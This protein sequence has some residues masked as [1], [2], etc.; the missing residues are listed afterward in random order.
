MKD[1]SPSLV[2]YIAASVLVLIGKAFGF[3]LLMLI[4]KPMVVPAIYFYYLQTKA[5]KT[6][7]LFSI[8]LWSF[9][10]ADMIMLIYARDAIIYIMMCGLVSYLILIGFAI[11]DRPS[12]KVT[13]LNVVFLVILLSVLS[14][15][16]FTILN[17]HVID[18]VRHYLVYLVYGISLIALVTVSTFNYLQ[19]STAT[20]LHLCSMALCVLISDL[21][22][23]INQFMVELPIIDHINLF[24]Q[25]LSYFFMVRYFNSRNALINTL[26]YGTDQN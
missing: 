8:V 15:I 10:V 19:Q 23:A 12:K 22:Y 5:G 26:D 13:A 11:A 20:F 6:N 14:Y 24:A 2:L 4:V 21:F 18:I 3:E 1:S 25:F 7:I 17:L 9:F 16:L